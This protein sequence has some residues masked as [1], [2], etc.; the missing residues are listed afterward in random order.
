MLVV[1]SASL[2]TATRARRMGAKMIRLIP[3]IHVAVVG[4]SALTSTFQLWA[5]HSLELHSSAS[6]STC[7]STGPSNFKSLAVITLKSLS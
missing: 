3:S 2:I 7:P 4:V 6:L 1:I 5:C